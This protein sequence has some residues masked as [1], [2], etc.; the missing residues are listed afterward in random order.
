MDR[1]TSAE[2][3]ADESADAE[4][5]DAPTDR[6]EGIHDA[7][8]AA[9][10]RVVVLNPASGDGS[11]ADR[12]RELAADRGFA[13][14]ETKEAGDAVR[15]TREAV[16]NGARTVAACGGDGTV[17]EVVRGLDEADALAEVTLGVVP[18]GTGNNFASNI[19]INGVEE[20]FTVMEHDRTRTVD[21]GVANGRPFMNSCVGGLTAEASSETSSEM[22]ERFGVLAYVTATLRTLQDYEGLSL[23]VADGH[24]EQP[25]WE[26]SA[27]CVFV[28]NARGAG[29]ERV[30]PAD[31]EDGLFDVTIVESMPPTE[32]LETA[33]V[34][35]L[36]GE[37]RDAVTRLQTPAL[38]VDVSGEKGA[39]FSLDGEML[40][41]NELDARVREGV[42]SLHVGDDYTP[43]PETGT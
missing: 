39:N 26:G 25:L 9:A 42:L 36:F 21:V 27:V 11:H 24:S 32:L 12:V 30:V 3:N 6:T 4:A 17:N 34:Y 20:A 37:D 8:E 2:E 23:S 14:F 40:S 16:A 7:G 1:T 15:L 19:G 43:H 35:R 29:R 28:G 33:A 41:S 31:M 38:T 5:G 18:G 22:K 10:R 13:V